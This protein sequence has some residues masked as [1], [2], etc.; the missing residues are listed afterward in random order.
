MQQLLAHPDIDVYV[1]DIRG[2]TPLALALGQMSD[3]TGKTPSKTE[4]KEIE[5]MLRAFMER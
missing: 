1:K 3:V 2:D 4:Y 5:D